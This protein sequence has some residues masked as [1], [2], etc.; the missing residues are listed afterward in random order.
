M[1]E[2]FRFGLLGEQLSPGAI[3]GGIA[4]GAA[5][6]GIYSGYTMVA[7]D[8]FGSALDIVGP[9]NPTGKYFTTKGAYSLGARTNSALQYQYDTDP[10]FTGAQDANRGVACGFNTMSQSSSALNLTARGATT[11]EQAL[12]NSKPILTSMIHTG[13]FMVSS[14][15]CVIEARVKLTSN[16]S[17]PL[18]W[19][20]TFWIINGN[21]YSQE[22]NAAPGSLEF[23]FEGTSNGT[24]NYSEANFFAHGSTTGPGNST[25]TDLGIQDGNW[26]ILTFVLT[27]SGCSYY[28]DGTFNRTVAQDCTNTSKPYYLLLTSHATPTSLTPWANPNGATMSVD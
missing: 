2:E 19:H 18:G 13:G 21:P 10:L 11:G 12:A 27:S 23:D 14:A 8:D 22:V 20:P 24:N 26:H 1:L 28:V 25:G 7:G 6:S 16:S 17:S 5:G 15:P 9:A 3:I 4:V